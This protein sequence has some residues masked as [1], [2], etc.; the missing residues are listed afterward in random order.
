VALR[1]PRST[2]IIEGDIER[3]FERLH[4]GRL[5]HL[6]RRRIRDERLLRVISRFLKAGYLEQWKFYGTYSGTPQGG[7]LSPLLA[8]IYLHELDTFL[9]ARLK[10]NRSRES[11]QEENARRTPESRKIDNRLAWLRR[12]LNGHTWSRGKL[13]EITLTAEERRNILKE[14]EVLEKSKRHTPTLRTRQTIGYVRYAD[15]YLILL[16]QH[17]KAEAECVKHQVEAYLRTD[18]H[19]TQ[20]AEK[21]LITHP[22]KPVKFLGFILTSA[23]GRRKGLRLDIPRNAP[24]ELLQEVRH[25]CQFHQMNEADL[26]LKVNRVVRGWMNYYRYANRP[27]RTFDTVLYRVFWQVC[28]YLARKHRTSIPVVLRRY[29]TSVTKSGRTRKTLRKWVGGQAVDLWLTPPS[30]E[31]VLGGR[32]S[33]FTEEKKPHLLHEWATGRSREQ[34]MAALEEAGY[35][36]QNPHCGTRDNLEAHHRG[37]LRGYRSTKSMAEA[38][39]AKDRRVLC[40]ACHLQIGHRGAFRPQSRER[41]GGRS[42]TGVSEAEM[43]PS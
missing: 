20:R 11:K 34:R 35:H 24:H 2:W 42:A 18:L 7:V 16:Q 39:A 10:A 41:S 23:G 26:F 19:L 8:N 31:H 12:K 28:H 25:L 43:S 1:F 13:V 6:L 37:G 21:T 3:C 40:Q 9:E 30:T 5:L 27:Q 33:R 22:T 38:G 36:C 32:L 29:A 15:D 14:C 4:H 17:S